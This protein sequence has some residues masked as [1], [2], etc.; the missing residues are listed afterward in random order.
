MPA[1]LRRG[2]FLTGPALRFSVTLPK[3]PEGTG[4]NGAVR[5]VDIATCLIRSFFAGEPEKEILRMVRGT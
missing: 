3:K 2:T 5:K 1:A 4:E